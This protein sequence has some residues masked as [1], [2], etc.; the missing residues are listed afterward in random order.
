MSNPSPFTP[1]IGFITYIGKIPIITLIQVDPSVVWKKKIN[2]E[3]EINLLLDPDKSNHDID[4][5]EYYKYSHPTTPARFTV[6]NS[7]EDNDNFV[8]LQIKEQF[9]SLD[10]HFDR[11]T[12]QASKEMKDVLYKFG[13]NLRDGKPELVKK[14]K[15]KITVN[16]LSNVIVE[17]DVLE[18]NNDF[19]NN[20]FTKA[21]LTTKDAAEDAAEDCEVNGEK[22]FACG[23]SS[24]GVTAAV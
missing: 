14:G 18:S 2:L 24:F 19:M 16:K 10:K 22:V 20:L 8:I 21:A 1:S 3:K 11:I 23:A 4:T 15:G 5:I 9:V 12:I 13:G 7:K 17:S 6:S